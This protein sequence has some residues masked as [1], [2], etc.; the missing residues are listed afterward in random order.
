[1]PYARHHEVGASE[2]TDFAERQASYGG[3]CN[4][5]FRHVGVV[6]VV[7]SGFVVGFACYELSYHGEGENHANHTERIGHRA[8]QG[9]SFGRQPELTYSLLGRAERGR[10]GCSAA[11]YTHH[12]GHRNRHEIAE[13][14]GRERA[15]HH[16]PQSE[17]IEFDAAAAE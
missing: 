17:Q 5:E 12:I 4:A 13:R 2:G 15:C 3:I 16:Q 11:E 14:Y 9:R 7:A 1:M 6:G 10:V 8:A